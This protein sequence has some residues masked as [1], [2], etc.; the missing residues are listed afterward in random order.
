MKNSH[1]YITSLLLILVGALKAQDFHMSQ[2]QTVQL[3]QNPAKTGVFHDL[4]TRDADYR[5]TIDFRSQWRSVGIRPF[6][7]M[8]ASYDQKVYERWGV[9][10]YIVNNRSNFGA[11]NMFQLLA[12]GSYHIIEPGQPHILTF[13]ANIG[14]FHKNFRP[15]AFTYNNQYNGSIDGGFDLSMDNGENFQKLSR[16]NADIGMGIFYKLVEEGQEVKPHAGL[17]VLHLNRP[18]EGLFSQKQRLPM[19]WTAELGFEFV[20]TDDLSFDFYNQYM[21]QNEAHD[22][23]LGMDVLYKLDDDYSLLGGIA[24]RWKD[25]A[26]ANLGIIYGRSLIRVSYDINTSPLKTYSGGRGAFE[27]GIVINGAK[28]EPLFAKSYN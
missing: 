12:S 7:T 1:I 24:Y 19:R 22:Y 18:N 4:Y 16:F 6:V 9:G 27:L 25:A 23:M 14:L 3:Y 2:Y 20:F 10:G 15:D 26:V 28:G 17:S 5:A 11:M 8:F 13:G 21:Y